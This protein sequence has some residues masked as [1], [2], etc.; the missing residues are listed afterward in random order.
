MRVQRIPKAVG[1]PRSFLEEEALDAAMKVFW[2]DGYEGASLSTLT[3]AMGINRP[4]LYAAFGDKKGLFMRVLERYERIT[5][6]YVGEALEKSTARAAVEALLEGAV[7]LATSP[8]N[9]RGCLITQ[10]ALACSAATT[11][12]QSK[13]KRRRNAGE[14]ALRLR[15]QRAQAEGDL[16]P[17]ADAAGLARYVVTVLQGIGVQAAS[18]ASRA[19]LQ[20]VIQTALRAW[21]K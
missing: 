10:S 16:P 12:I 20:K 19:N 14:K 5:T 17:N 7:K 4:S 15:L 3:K 11:D 9:P 2:H 8:G 6:A 13:L 21:P 1:R 18:G